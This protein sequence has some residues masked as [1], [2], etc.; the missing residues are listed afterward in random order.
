MLMMSA[1]VP[2][3]AKPA[4]GLQVQDD[5]CVL[6]IR[7]IIREY[8]MLITTLEM[9]N[10]AKILHPTYGESSIKKHFGK[11]DNDYPITIE[12]T[13]KV[14]GFTNALLSLRA[15]NN[16]HVRRLLGADIVEHVLK[17]YGKEYCG[18]DDFV[19][20]IDIIK[21]GNKDEL[22]EASFL[23]G[24]IVSNLR[25]IDDN[26]FTDQKHICIASAVS[27]AAGI[28]REHLSCG[29]ILCDNLV[30]SAM[31]AREAYV[32]HKYGF[33]TNGD[34]EEYEWQKERLL[35]YCSNY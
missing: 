25:T 27:W 34:Y 35:W 20:I 24:A 5:I 2:F 31:N 3:V 30:V 14:Y 22:L 28:G 10:K 6:N 4:F 29:I 12:E 13:L 16:T 9:L 26:N 33:P 17:Y 15:C 21:K 23:T 8:M 11:I 32:L 19:K 18:K 1:H 7:T